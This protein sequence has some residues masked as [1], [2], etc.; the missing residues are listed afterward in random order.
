MLTCVSMLLYAHVCKFEKISKFSISIS[1]E[2]SVNP[3]PVS[4]ILVINQIVKEYFTRAELKAVANI[5]KSRGH[6]VTLSDTD[7]LDGQGVRLLFT[8][9]VNGAICC[10]VMDLDFATIDQIR[11]VI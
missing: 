7:Y 9:G 11:L 6:L 4:L 5:F 3:T 1:S 8:N 10:L 2:P